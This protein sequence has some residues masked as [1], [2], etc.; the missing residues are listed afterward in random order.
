MSLRAVMI[1]CSHCWVIASVCLCKMLVGFPFSPLQDRLLV[2]FLH[3]DRTSSNFIWAG[4]WNGNDHVPRTALMR[5]CI[6]GELTAACAIDGSRLGVKITAHLGPAVHTVWSA[7]ADI[8]TLADVDGFLTAML[9]GPLIGHVSAAGSITRVVW[10][11]DAIT[12]AQLVSVI[13]FA[14]TTIPEG[15]RF[16][17]DHRATAHLNVGVHFP[18]LTD[19]NGNHCGFYISGRGSSWDETSATGTASIFILSRTNFTWFCT[20]IPWISILHILQIKKT[21]WNQSDHYIQ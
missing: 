12:A 16:G 15:R 7:A 4:L 10:A 1:P 9:G 18:T 11:E 19:W 2:V 21:I 13:G 20:N 3:Q 8:V 5:A 6:E 17:V 14:A